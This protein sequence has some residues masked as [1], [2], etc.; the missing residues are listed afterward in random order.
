MALLSLAVACIVLAILAYVVGAR[1][2]AGF[3]MEIARIAILLFLILAV[4]S[5]FL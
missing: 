1:G 5:F 2:I 4:V 3:T